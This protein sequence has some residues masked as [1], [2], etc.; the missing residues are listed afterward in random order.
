MY[1]PNAATIGWDDSGPSTGATVHVLSGSDHDAVINPFLRRNRRGWWDTLGEDALVDDALVY[2]ELEDEATAVRTFKIDLVD[3]LMQTPEYTAAVIQA[4]QP[5][6]SEELV[7]RQ[8]DARTRRQARLR[9]ANPL[10]VEAVIT[11]NALRN[12]VGGPTIMRHQLEHLLALMELPNVDLWVVPATGAY[13]AMGLPFYILSF[14]SRY[15]DVGYVELLDKGV[16]VE[17]PADVR[18]YARKFAG[19]RA[20]ALGPEPSRDLIV[21]I[22]EGR[23]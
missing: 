11:E 15:P 21:A 19:L 12:P 6:V 3:G 1:E 8:V 13:P 9:G 2:V 17:E 18:R 14:D 10:H 7:R 23:R 20:V 16:Y 5:S 22:G 4:D